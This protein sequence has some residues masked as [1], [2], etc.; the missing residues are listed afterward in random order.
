MTETE[1]R[2]CDI[3]E[4]LAKLKDSTDLTDLFDETSA[5]FAC[6]EVTTE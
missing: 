5:E 6:C 1:E 2:A 4:E 3:I